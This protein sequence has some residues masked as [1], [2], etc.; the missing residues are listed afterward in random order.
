M[1]VRAMRMKSNLKVRQ[2]LKRIILPIADEHDL[3]EMKKTEEIILEEINVKSIEYVADD[4]GIVTKKAKANFKAIGPKFGKSVQQ[5]AERIKQLNTE[6]IA[7]LERGGTLTFQ[8][9]G[10]GVT[11]LREDVEITREDIAGWLVETDDGLTVA[12]DTSL[13]E[14]LVAEGVAREFVNRIQNLRKDAGFDVTDRITIRVRASEDM[15]RVL[16]SL[17]SYIRKE[18]LAEEFSTTAP[19]DGTNA[20]FELNGEEVSVT[21]MRRPRQ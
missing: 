1:L 3:G 13:N 20:A 5:V 11:I 21:I 18:T 19:G 16:L 2:P 14:E 8:V 15:T 12:L 17:A 4:S 9:N 6:E 10:S 7:E